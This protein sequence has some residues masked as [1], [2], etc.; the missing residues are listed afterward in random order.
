MGY[1]RFTTVQQTE[2]RYVIFKISGTG[3]VNSG[4]AWVL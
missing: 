4:T 1:N 2:R 3:V